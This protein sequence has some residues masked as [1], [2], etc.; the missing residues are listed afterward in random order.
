MEEAQRI[1]RNAL[2]DAKEMI[3]DLCFPASHMMVRITSLRAVVPLLKNRSAQVMK[4]KVKDAMIDANNGCFQIETGRTGGTIKR[5]TAAQ[6][7]REMDISQL[8]QELFRD[9]FA[10][11]NEWV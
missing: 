2:K 1:C 11:L 6:A 3:D 9:T 7:K 8:T 5:I 10:Y 4:V